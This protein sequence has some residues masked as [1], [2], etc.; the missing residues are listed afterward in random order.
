MHMHAGNKSKVPYVQ[1]GV[2]EVAVFH[3]SIHVSIPDKYEHQLPP[4]GI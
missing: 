2:L 1:E 3:V 4:T